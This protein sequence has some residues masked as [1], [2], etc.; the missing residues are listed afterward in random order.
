MQKDLLKFNNNINKNYKLA[1]EEKLQVLKDQKMVFN[2]ILGRGKI[3]KGANWD[4][5][6]LCA[7]EKARVLDLIV[8]L[9]NFRLKIKVKCR[10]FIV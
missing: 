7:F 4:T 1:K 2:L 3:F 10:K 8:I 6:T 9:I 5:K